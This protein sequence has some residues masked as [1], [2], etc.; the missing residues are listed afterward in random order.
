MGTARLTQSRGQG[1][2]LPCPNRCRQLDMHGYV[3]RISASR[4]TFTYS[5][6][7]APSERGRKS[8]VV[9]SREAQWGKHTRKSVADNSEKLNGCKVQVSIVIMGAGAGFLWTSCRVLNQDQYLYSPTDL[10]TMTLSERGLYV[11][12]P[13]SEVGLPNTIWAFSFQSS[14]MLYLWA[15]FASISGL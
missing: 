1:L 8:R 13:G 11:F 14:A 4:R 12:S 2:S 3:P 7:H 9:S 10:Y 6:C 15:T 5:P